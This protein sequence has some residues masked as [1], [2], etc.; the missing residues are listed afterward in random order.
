MRRYR[1]HGS[2]RAFL[3]T[4]A[5]QVRPLEA[6][7]DGRLDSEAGSLRRTAHGVCLLPKNFAVGRAAVEIALPQ[8]ETHLPAGL[9]LAVRFHALG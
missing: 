3:G 5:L 4:C 2:S 7:E 9:V 8:I 6:I 1:R